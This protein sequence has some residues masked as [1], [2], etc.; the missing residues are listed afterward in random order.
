MSKKK[1][2]NFESI[3][4]IQNSNYDLLNIIFS[5]IEYSGNKINSFYEYKK[6]INEIISNFK[7]EIEKLNIE[8]INEMKKTGKIFEY[9]NSN[10]KL[11]NCYYNKNIKYFNNNVAIGSIFNKINNI[12]ASTGIFKG[13]FVFELMPINDSL[14]KSIIGFSL[15]S[16]L[17][18]NNSAIGIN[19]SSESFGFVLNNRKKIK[20]SVLTPFGDF[21][22]EGDI[23]GVCLDLNEGFCEMFINGVKYG[24]IFDKLNVSSNFVYYPTFS[25]F[26]NNGIYCN[27][28][29]I[30]KFEFEYE[31]YDAIDEIISKLNGV[32]IITIKF[33]EILNKNGIKILNDKKINEVIKLEIFNKILQFLF[34]VS[35]ND[36]FIV[37]NYIFPFL[38]ENEEN[39]IIFKYNQNF[40]INFDKFFEIL[41]LEILY[42]SYRK[43]LK[44][45][46]NLLNL[47]YN[48]ITNNFIINEYLKE[49]FIQKYLNFVFRS[50]YFNFFNFKFINKEI[51]N[52]YLENIN[53]DIYENKLFI[54]SIKEIR[55][56]VWKNNIKEEII[57][58]QIEIFQKILKLS[59]DDFHDK[60]FY[61]QI[62]NNYL[63]RN[64]ETYLELILFPLMKTFLDCF[65]NKNI[66]DLII[67]SWFK[68]KRIKKSENL[69]GTFNNL[70]KN[71]KNK[72]PN[73][74]ELKNTKKNFISKIFYDILEKLQNNIEEILIFS[75]KFFGFCKN[76]NLNDFKNSS[77]HKL[78][79]YLTIFNENVYYFNPFYQKILNDFI[80]IL[81]D[82]FLFLY[83]KN[84]IY[85]LPLKIIL[86]PFKFLSIFN[87]QML[88][89]Q[90]EE[91][92]KT[93]D[94]IINFNLKLLS[95]KLV[96]NPSL[97]EQ[98]LKILFMIF[99]DE[100][101]QKFF[102]NDFYL[103]KFFSVLANLCIDVECGKFVSFIICE[104]F[105]KFKDNFHLNSF[106]IKII[107]F[108]KNNYQIFSNLFEKFNV[109][110]NEIFSNLLLHI[111]DYEINI[112]ENP[113]F[114]N[115][116]HLISFIIILKDC[117]SL[118]T[119]S[120]FYVPDHI[121]NENN[122]EL[123][124]LINLISNISNRLFNKEFLKIIFTISNDNVEIEKFFILLF[125]E[126]KDIFKYL[127]RNISKKNYENAFKI[128]FKKKDE[129]NLNNLLNYEILNTKK[130]FK[131][132]FDEIFLAKK[133][134]EKT[135]D[136]FNEEEQTIKKVNK[137]NICSI[138]LENEITH[139]FLPCKHGSCLL[140]LKQYLINYNKCFLCKA[141]I[142]KIQEDETIKII[143]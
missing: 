112:N 42:Y 66:N 94:K 17:L 117:L 7:P 134:L 72:I 6:Y 41:S 107:E 36:Y 44:K 128:F 11:V 76:T 19:E 142:E 98:L 68:K 136:K 4:S 120:L 88:F 28:G 69:G 38:M 23:I 8:N 58:E 86:I 65:K 115:K 130:K 75:K 46:K 137:E 3:H 92:L 99:Q 114:D 131:L 63:C 14:C 2:K 59:Y 135:F 109:Q 116:K 108:F 35:F 119:F 138:C 37:S 143:E 77:S 83:E 18:D 113:F 111:E 27:F 67:N 104:I 74:E 89:Y 100:N 125:K 31:N 126:I 34:N 118:F 62:F 141:K 43:N 56:L 49:N 105:K 96:N 60:K 85:Y 24:K 73:F 123:I 40:K 47:F 80:N 12:R 48:L 127:L 13:K 84:I 79:Y 55:N 124:Q 91:N 32:E 45:W 64:V 106:N 10:T 71:F 15:L 90:N 129:L 78:I 33:L 21:I 102:E 1:S 50:F 81:L 101:Q 51:E 61:K 82:Y 93:I 30:K 54:D 133:I 25:L 132:I 52:K 26:K 16:D 121:L 103:E 9:S 53:N 122:I 22:N 20:K 39:F 5:K 140:C 110:L 70:E 87:N 57:K 97:R 139:H 95:D 29:G